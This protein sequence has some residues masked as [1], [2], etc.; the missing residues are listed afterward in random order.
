MHAV[1]CGFDVVFQLV[2]FV[3]LRS[4]CLAKR[5]TAGVRMRVRCSSRDGAAPAPLWRRRPH[6]L[7]LRPMHSPL[8]FSS[9]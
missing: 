2:I 9:S 8:I 5:R 4:L 7:P 6:P 3:V 1:F